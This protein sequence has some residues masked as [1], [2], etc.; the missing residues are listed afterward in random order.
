MPEENSS[1]VPV[2]DKISSVVEEENETLKVSDDKSESDYKIAKNYYE[3]KNYK[4]ALNYFLKAAEAGNHKTMY[5]LSVMYQN[6]E[7]VN[8]DIDK[9][10]EW[11]FG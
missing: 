3:A 11:K 4:D 10:K 1:T 2:D 7:G 8:K 6:G 5:N 9:S